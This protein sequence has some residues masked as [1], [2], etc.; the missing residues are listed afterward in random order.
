MYLKNQNTTILTWENKKIMN[1]L[2]HIFFFRNTASGFLFKKKKCTN[3][4]KII[5]A[6]VNLTI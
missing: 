6:G 5:F 1:Y 4:K 2:R 3:T